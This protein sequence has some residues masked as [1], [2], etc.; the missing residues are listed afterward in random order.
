MRIFSGRTPKRR[1]SRQGGPRSTLLLGGARSGKSALAERL[2]ADAEDVTYVATGGTRT[3]DAEWAQR[4]AAHRD[5]RPAV[6]RTEETCDLEPLLAQ[7]GGGPLLVDCLSLW[8]TAALDE[9]D[10]WDPDAWRDGGREA[11][12]ARTGALVAAWRASPRRVVG[13]SN[14]VGSGVVP[15][16]PAGR[17]FRDELGRLN[18]ELAAASDEVLLV[19]A[20]R[21]LPLLEPGR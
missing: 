6:W 12:R 16:T 8:L 4:V 7:R 14:E 10:A 3:G 19:V 1:T 11:L 21:V 18:T 5:R 17:L 2:L 20:G 13:V 15:A 9:A